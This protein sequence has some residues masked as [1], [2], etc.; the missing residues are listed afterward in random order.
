[1][2]LRRDLPLAI[3]VIVVAGSLG[4]FVWAPYATAHRL[5]ASV[6]ARDA[7]ALLRDIDHDTLRE[8]LRNEIATLIDEEIN[9]EGQD[10][11]GALGAALAGIFILPMVDHLVTPE[12]LAQLMA[13]AAPSTDEGDAGSPSG[14]RSEVSLGYEDFNTF[15]IRVTPHF[16][17]D[18]PRTGESE[19]A[20]IVFVLARHDWQTWKLNAIRLPRG[21]F[22]QP[23]QERTLDGYAGEETEL[24]ADDSFD[25]QDAS[26]F[27][28]EGRMSMSEIAASE[29][30][31]AGPVQSCLDEKAAEWRSSHAQEEEIPQEDLDAWY[32]D[33]AP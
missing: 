8:N 30:T 20:A 25:S 24:S 13:G 33:C 21:T 23:E 16:P 19:E 6:A 32:M 5:Q 10:A 29:D 4:W 1:M 12:G 27:G 14:D 26:G 22:R 28:D 18:A 31:Q 7:G 9:R 11:M 17:V 2:N 15:L 3:F